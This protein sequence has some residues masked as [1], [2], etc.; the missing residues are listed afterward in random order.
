MESSFFRQ[1]S[2]KLSEQDKRNL[3]MLMQE[4]KSRAAAL[5]KAKKK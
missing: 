5:E 1:W 3:S 2:S 4:G